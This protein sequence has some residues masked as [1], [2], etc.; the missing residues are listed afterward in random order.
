MLGKII[1]RGDI[2]YLIDDPVIEPGSIQRHLETL[3]QT[4]RDTGIRS[5]LVQGASQA[6]EIE[7]DMV[8]TL[9]AMLAASIPRDTRI[10]FAHADIPSVADLAERVCGC[11]NEIGIASIAA[12]TQAAATDWLRN[13]TADLSG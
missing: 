5:L 13:V 11:L 7:D 1:V 9:T 4:L 6:V 10:A 3:G 12:S 8:V 2:V